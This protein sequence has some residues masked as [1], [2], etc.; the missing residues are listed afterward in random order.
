[1]LN[2][3][4][5]SFPIPILRW[6]IVLVFFLVGFLPFS[7]AYASLS[8]TT[9]A[10]SLD[11]LRQEIDTL[12]SQTGLYSVQAAR[13]LADLSRLETAIAE[14][15]DRATI[16]NASTHQLGVIVHNPTKASPEPATFTV[17]A[18]GHQTD[19]DVETTALYIPA[20]ISLRW[21]GQPDESLSSVARV[22]RL[23][24]GEDLRV[25][26]TQTGTGYFLNLPPFAL[27]TDFADLGR[28]PSLNQSE[29][30]TQPETAPV[31]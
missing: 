8:A 2:R 28:L 9:P 26:D 7:P 19:D 15:T 12:E 22:V 16:E 24:P 27:D 17:L 31:D 20:N 23:L 3:R 21:P 18:A 30:D 6:V 5:P 25:S 13:R 4:L 10:P 11:L 14:S 29:L 1:M